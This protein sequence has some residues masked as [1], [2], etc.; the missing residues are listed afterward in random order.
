[1]KIKK[2]QPVKT[3]LT[4]MLGFM[5]VYWMTKLQW[6]FSLAFLVG[7]IGLLSNYLAEKIDFLWMKLTWLLS[8]IVPNILMSIVF[9]AFLFPIALL[10][11]IFG[12][13]DTLNLKNKNISL[14]KN[15]NKEFSKSSFERPW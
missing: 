8:L 4:I 14:F 1:M 10:S 15:T 3:I 13:S 6:A 5:V 2:S 9:F 11:R 7:A 12:K